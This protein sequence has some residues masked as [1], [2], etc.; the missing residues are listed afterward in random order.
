M[1]KK[2]ITKNQEKRLEEITLLIKNYR[3]NDGL[4][5]TEFSRISDLHVNT[6]RR[7]E[8]GYR[9]ISLLTLFSCIDSMDI[10]IAEFF[11]GIK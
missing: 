5:Q 3:L 10:T 11:E 6:I 2:A 8:S 1:S 9:N 7:L 4:T